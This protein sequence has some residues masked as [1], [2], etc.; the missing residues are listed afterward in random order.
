MNVEELRKDT[1]KAA[2][3]FKKS[4]AGEYRHIGDYVVKQKGTAPKKRTVPVIPLSSNAGVMRP[5]CVLSPS[6][7]S[8]CEEV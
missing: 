6:Q 3:L 8:E 7:P 4:P 1:K 2:P 5:Q